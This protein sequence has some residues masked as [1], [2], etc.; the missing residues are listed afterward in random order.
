MRTVAVAATVAL[1]LAACSQTDEASRR[2]NKPLTPQ[3]LSLLS[4]KQ[5]APSSPILVRIFKKESELEVWKETADGQ[6]A[7][8]KTYPICRWSGELGP[9]VKVGDRQAP[10]GFYTIAPGQMNPNSGYYLSFNLGFPNAFDKAYGR[11]GEFLMVHGDCSSSG[12]YAMTDEQ[13]SEIFSLARESFAGGQRAF[14]VQAYPFR[15]TP[16]NLA[17][18]RKNPNL[19]FWKNLKEGYD[20]FEVTR[21]EPRVNVCERRY[22][23][24]AE[25]DLGKTF[26]AQQ[27]CPPYRVDEQVAQAVAAKSRADEAQVAALSQSAPVAPVRTGRDGGMHPVFLA[28]FKRKQAGGSGEYAFAPQ[29]PGTVPETTRPPRGED[30]T[31]TAEA[32]AAVASAPS[33]APAETGT[34]SARPVPAP[35]AGPRVAS[36][37]PAPVPAPPAA[38]PASGAPSA[39]ETAALRTNAAPPAPKPPAKPTT[40]GAA[41]GASQSTALLPPAGLTGAMPIVSTGSFSQ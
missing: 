3:M 33:P 31:G 29:A 6:Y 9:K 23:F 39:A 12:C 36:V 24:D 8:L 4:Q 22:V 19:A 15:M 1:A 21:Q 40:P 11:T 30:D 37:A 7:L 34:L 27:A 18:N 32:G 38:R 14:Q 5:M 10:E 2:A 20:H 28:E 13:I 26:N 35:A 25:P 16:K 17:E 41:S